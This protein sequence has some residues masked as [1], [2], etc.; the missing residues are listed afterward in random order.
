MNTSNAFFWVVY[1]LAIQDYYILIPNGL[2]FMFGLM[3]TMLYQC[4]T[5]DNGTTDDKTEQQFL[6]DDGNSRESSTEII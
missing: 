1:G 5:H 6:D 4:Y 2:G 3:Q